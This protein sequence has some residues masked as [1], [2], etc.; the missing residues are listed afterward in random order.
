MSV[1]PNDNRARQFSPRQVVRLAA[2]L[3][4]ALVYVVPPQAQSTPP[5]AQPC[6]VS[7]LVQSGTVPLPGA[8]VVALGAGDVEISSTSSEPNGTYVLRVGAPGTYRI[9][10]SLAAFAPV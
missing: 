8:A 5:A 6:T 3:A 10:A 2:G 1:S 9:R 4:L 7:G